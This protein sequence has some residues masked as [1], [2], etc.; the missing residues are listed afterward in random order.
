MKKNET[1][2][3]LSIKP[4]FV[5]LIFNGIKTVELRKA[6]PSNLPDRTEIII[7]A[8]S[9]QKC[10]VGRAKVKYIE[11]H[12]VGQLWK[13]LGHKT[14]INFEY[15]KKY[16]AGHKTGYGIVLDRVEKFLSPITLE[17]LREELNFT[18]PQSYMYTPKAILEALA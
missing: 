10:I 9:P 4:E 8:S 14:G 1:S 11:K 17:D 13:K 7:Y 18:P 12:S 5:E 6:L 2:I 16:F 15:F 3:L